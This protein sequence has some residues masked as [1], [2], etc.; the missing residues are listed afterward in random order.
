[1]GASW[2]LA[3]ADLSAVSLDKL[4]ETKDPPTW[5]RQRGWLWKVSLSPKQPCPCPLLS[6][7]RC[8]MDLGSRAQ[9]CSPDVPLGAPLKGCFYSLSPVPS[10]PIFAFY[11]LF[12][13]YSFESEMYSRVSKLKAQKAYSEI[14]TFINFLCIFSSISTCKEKQM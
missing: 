12:C 5:G 11:M 13:V 4:Q 7:L 2:P 9:P 3:N 1:M 6:F 14:T 8:H 10:F